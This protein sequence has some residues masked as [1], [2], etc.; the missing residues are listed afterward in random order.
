M[1]NDRLDS[2]RTYLLAVTRDLISRG[3]I[4]KGAGQTLDQILKI[5]LQTVLM[6]VRDDLKAIGGEMLGGF[7]AGAISGLLGGGQ[8]R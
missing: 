3:L 2:L 1:A 5:E 4:R 6:H 7:V 8:K